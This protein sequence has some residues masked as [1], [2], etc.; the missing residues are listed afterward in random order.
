LQSYIVNGTG[1]ERLPTEINDPNDA[2]L[3]DPQADCQPAGTAGIYNCIYQIDRPV[4]G[5]G[6]RNQGIEISYQQ[7][8]WR[9]FGVLA[10]YTYSDAEADSG[11]PIPSNSEH[12][13]NLTAF[14]ENPRISAR[15]SYNYR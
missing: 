14:Y 11:D 6:G 7:P 12:T 13:V 9:G 4:N 15:V 10:N 3:S 2:R 5:S 1:P 8:L